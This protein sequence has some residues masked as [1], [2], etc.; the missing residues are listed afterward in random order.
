MDGDDYIDAHYCNPDPQAE[1][2]IFYVGVHAYYGLASFELV[3][4]TQHYAPNIALSSLAYE[5]AKF[6]LS[7]GA[8]PQ[9]D[10]GTEISSCEFVPYVFCDQDLYGCC[11]RYS[12]MSPTENPNPLWPWSEYDTTIGQYY[13]KLP[14]SEFP[15]LTPGKLAFSLYRGWESSNARMVYSSVSDPS[16]CKAK[17]S[18]QLE[19]S[20][21]RQLPSLELSFVEKLLTCDLASFQRTKQEMTEL[22]QAME[23]AENSGSVQDLIAL[24]LT[25]GSLSNSDAL[26]G[27][28][29]FSGRFSVTSQTI[30]TDTIYSCPWPIASPEWEADPCCNPE[31]SHRTSCRPRDASRSLTSYL[32]ADETTIKQHCRHWECS[33]GTVDQWTRS[34]DNSMC[35]QVF[36]QVASLSRLEDLTH[37]A[38]ACRFSIE[39]KAL[40][41]V[42]CNSDSDCFYGAACVPETKLCAHTP[43]HVLQC[44]VDNISEDMSRILYS[45]WS[46]I[47]PTEPEVLKST[48]AEKTMD[49]QCVGPNAIGYRERYEYVPQT[50]TCVDD[51]LRNGMQP[52]CFDV[53]DPAC[54]IPPECDGGQTEGACYR[55]WV[56]IAQDDVGCLDSKICNWFLPDFHP[57]PYGSDETSCNSECAL[58][59]SLSSHVCLDCTQRSNG[60][61]LEVESIS[62]E[63]SCLVPQCSANASISDAQECE[64]F[65]TCTITCQGCEQEATC[66]AAGACSSDFEFSDFLVLGATG[67]CIY[68]SSWTYASGYSCDGAN[69]I[70]TTIGC[71]NVSVLSASEC[72]SNHMWFEF[73]TNESSCSTTAGSG[74]YDTALG[75]F[76]SRNAS[77]CAICEPQGCLWTAYYTW[78]VGEWTRGQLRQ[79]MWE[80]RRY[81]S[82]TSLALTVSYPKLNQLL[83][84][85][86]IIVAAPA[87]RTD[88]LCRWGAS[89][90]L[91]ESISCDCNPSTSSG[92]CFTQIKNTQMGE[93]T[94]CPYLDTLITARLASV[95]VRN[96]TLERQQ[97]C[98]K[99]HLS[100]TPSAQYQL[101]SNAGVTQALFRGT[102]TNAYWVVKNHL[103]ATVGQILSGGIT[104]DFDFAIDQPLTLCI[105]IDSSID[106]AKIKNK[107]LLHRFAMLEQADNS[108]RVL[109]GSDFQHTYIQPIEYQRASGNTQRACLDVKAQGTY[110]VVAVVQEY[111]T[112]SP[113]VSIAQYYI[114][115][116]IYAIIVLFGII[117]GGLLLVDR[118]KQKILKLKLI[119]IAVILLNATIRII[120]VLLPANA[121]GK[122]MDSIEFIVF[123]LPTFLF[124]SVFTAIAYL[125]L[126][127]VMKTYY[128]GRR[129]KV[130]QK[131]KQLRLGLALGNCFMYLVFVLFIYLIAIVPALAKT[132]PCFYGN[133]QTTDN[134][135]SYRIKLA[136]WIFQLV[137]SILLSAAFLIASVSLLK[138]VLGLKDTQQKNT[139]PTPTLAGPLK[140]LKGR[141]RSQRHYQQIYIISV[142]AAVCIIFLLIRSCIFLWA[143]ATGRALNV[144]V[145]VLLEAIPQAMLLF[146]VHPFQCFREEGRSSSTRSFRT[147]YVSSGEMTTRDRITTSSKIVH[148]TRSEPSSP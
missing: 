132:S 89:L 63:V 88:A 12:P 94:A 4:T 33:N 145:F 103:N 102:A 137:M 66:L 29:S 73:P 5:Q 119:F 65:G 36:S 7:V 49:I 100:S 134:R 112:L 75:A 122:G 40:R 84:S 68:P 13:T 14:V 115:A 77:E 39:G 45:S 57:C 6:D 46:M 51:C 108:I 76:V 126:V 114:G 56:P 9:L 41:G 52:R 34:S 62:D 78:Q 143:A 105:D 128:L 71:A 107:P 42:S 146:Y 144:I 1:Y 27:C 10:C 55:I 124:F 44:L 148:T 87:Y 147:S 90:N 61:C 79:Y 130:S 85:A 8:F 111:E 81:G 70:V 141:A 139:G 20:G 47:G 101:P 2:T 117:Q 125:W 98:A 121:F 60:A 140:G 18:G 83:D 120:Y 59:S 96:D 142:V 35:A 58:N 38:T 97:N 72:D 28:E 106:V 50:V 31:V 3:V 32:S 53:S 118:E 48:I 80:P 86:V 131:E 127:V 43:D 133:L 136:Y 24:Q 67:A 15:V 26:V 129:G 74:C 135:A 123:E 93:S 21:G 16:R 110:F 95:H 91:I 22:T 104:L 113:R 54:D 138:L 30:H 64:N 116:A 19:F 82:Q 25:L 92:S 17:M 69:D 23:V 37:F 99:L 109:E 11:W